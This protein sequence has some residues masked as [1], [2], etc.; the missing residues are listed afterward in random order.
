[1]AGPQPA[2]R[3]VR[4]VAGREF[5]CRVRS[6]RLVL[7]TVTLAV[8]L[9]GFLVLQAYVFGHQRTLRVGLAGQAISL[10]QALPQEMVA[11]GVP[12]G[13][14]QLDTVADGV[15]D[16]RAGR[17]DVLVSGARSAL[18]V[19]VDNQLDPRLRATLNSL[20][21]QQILDAQLAQLGARPDD[22]LAKV[23]QAQI[24]VTQLGVTD[25]N[26]GQR[27]TLGVI[28]ALL[29]AWS[30]CVGS[31]LAGRRVVDDVTGGTAEALLPV[32]RPRRLL[33]GNLAGIGL[34]VLVHAVV[35]G[36]VG[37]AAALATGAATVS[38]A[39]AVALGAGLLGFVV[40]YALYGT[41]AAAVTALRPRSRGV[42]PALIGVVFVVS[43]VLVAA[44][45]GGTATAVLS[46]LPPFAPLLVPARLA[47]GVGA[48]WEVLLAV[49]LAL[50][51]VAGLGWFTGRVYP[52]S[53]FRA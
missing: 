52:R 34:T 29:V 36:V 42:V 7:G 48:G 20:V 23:D 26:L 41:C 1:M 38:A 9:V 4:V 2:A 14:R 53:L 15:A 37:V 47:V 3:T 11:L 25:P 51:T 17:L 27:K 19:T 10:Q 22:V 12:V 8:L 16:V 6:R 21:R 31:L 33:T 13:V 46:V 50:V 45:P 49:V 35:L 39:V 44:A 28:T 43:A 18:R 30:L 5:G 24:T 32:L 40:G